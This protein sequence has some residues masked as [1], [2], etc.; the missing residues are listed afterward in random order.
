[1]S[2]GTVID[3]DIYR[4]V[5]NARPI[6]YTSG[7]RKVP[8]AT[9]VGMT[10]THPL[11]Y[12]PSH[13]PMFLSARK[14]RDDQRPG[15]WCIGGVRGFADS[16]ATLFGT[17]GGPRPSGLSVLPLARQAHPRTCEELGRV[18]SVECKLCTG[19]MQQLHVGLHQPTMRKLAKG[20]SPPVGP[21][22][23]GFHQLLPERAAAGRRG[24][25][26]CALRSSFVD[27]GEVSQRGFQRQGMSGRN[28]AVIVGMVEV[29]SRVLCHFGAAR[30]TSVRRWVRLY[31]AVSVHPFAWFANK[32]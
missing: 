21:S 2:I 22:R 20:A 32:R 5:F 10:H 9:V 7:V 1:M 14:A 8:S 30:S 27:R 12:G 19:A 6:T 3:G 28:K 11:T 29:L 24:I 25:T 18:H 13:A 15:N 23:G 31:R 16:A 26:L 17:A 4:Y